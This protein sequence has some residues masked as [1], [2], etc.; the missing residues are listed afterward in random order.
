IAVREALVRCTDKDAVKGIPVAE[1]AIAFARRAGDV[2]AE[3]IAR[4]CRSALL[5][6]IGRHREALDEAQ[7][8]LD[9]DPDTRGAARE[10]LAMALYSAGDIAKAKTEICEAL[11]LPDVPSP[12]NESVKRWL[13]SAS[14]I[15][16]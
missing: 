3:G 11:A 4:R 6:H 8:A 1:H 9:A 12:L 10:R 5:N 7:Q 2:E 14:V 16:Q 13:V 15:L